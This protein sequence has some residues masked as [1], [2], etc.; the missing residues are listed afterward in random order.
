[1]ERLDVSAAGLSL[2]GASVGS[3]E[4][5]DAAFAV[6]D[7][8]VGDAGA[9]AARAR[10]LD[11]AG[12]FQA[13]ATRELG[14]ASV[15]SLSGELHAVRATALVEAVEAG[16]RA[17]A[18]QLRQ[19]RARGDLA[20]ATG[21]L[22]W[23]S[24]LGVDAAWHGNGFSDARTRLGG[25][26]VGQQRLFGDGRSLG[27]TLSKARL[28]TQL[29]GLGGRAGALIDEAAVF[30][31][32]ASGSTW[33]TGRMMVG[34]HSHDTQRSV[35]LGWDLTGV[36]TRQAGSHRGLDLEAGFDARLGGLRLTPFASARWLQV[37]FDGFDETGAWGLGL[38]AD[39]HRAQLANAGLGLDLA[40]G[41]QG[42]GGAQH[43][44][45]ARMQWQP[46]LSGP[47]S[48]G[49]DAAFSGLGS[50]ARTVEGLGLSEQAGRLELGLES[51]LPG[52]G[53]FTLGLGRDFDARGDG[54]RAEA[55]WRLGF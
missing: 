1:M 53:R 48:L 28:D 26:V 50:G 29:D 55:S 20:A 9:D 24:G 43:T 39:G 23:S 11:G 25:Q 36:G 16:G 8:W 41:W 18:D 4:R 27:L 6:L 19:N 7:G 47:L 37:D 13:A 31:T 38:A 54:A 34:R 30:A 35:L 5:I 49:P 45:A 15:A 10:V 21:W 14:E 32:A 22:G 2:T 40:S 52:W 51:R 33:A 12:R 3:A 44:V 46:R 42:R 17:L